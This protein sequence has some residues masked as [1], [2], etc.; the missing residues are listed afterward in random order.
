MTVPISALVGFLVFASPP[1]W[2]FS[3]PAL[4]G[5]LPLSM[6][7]SFSRLAY[8]SVAACLGSDTPIGY[9]AFSHASKASMLAACGCERPL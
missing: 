9:G 6:E 7:P 8:R 4:V 3:R 2:V 5:G 1:F